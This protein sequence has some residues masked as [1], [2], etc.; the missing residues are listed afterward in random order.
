[1]SGSILAVLPGVFHFAQTD[2]SL[3][4]LLEFKLLNFTQS[5][6]QAFRAPYN[7]KLSLQCAKA[8]FIL[9]NMMKVPA[10]DSYEALVGRLE[11]SK[12]VEFDL[13]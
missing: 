5:I 9:N 11:A 13:R 2:Y 1:V 3:L 12:D 7:M 10:G 6:E 8:F 4:F